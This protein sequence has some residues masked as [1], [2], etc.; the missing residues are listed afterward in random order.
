MGLMNV[1]D[2]AFLETRHVV[3]VWKLDGVIFEI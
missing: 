2:T 1:V 3:Q